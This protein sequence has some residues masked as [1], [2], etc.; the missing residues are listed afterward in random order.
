M[1]RLESHT[2]KITASHKLHPLGVNASPCF[3]QIML[4]V[5]A[6][7]TAAYTHTRPHIY[8]HITVLSTCAHSVGLVLFCT[9]THR[10][11]HR[12]TR[13]QDKIAQYDAAYG[14]RVT[15]S[16]SCNAASL[17]PGTETGA[18]L[19]GNSGLTLPE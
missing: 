8:L 16:L 6:C 5:G 18:S 9:N 19:L 4:I 7:I 1:D 11:G 12:L 2:Q 13:C 10:C 15:L 17:P 3:E 14:H